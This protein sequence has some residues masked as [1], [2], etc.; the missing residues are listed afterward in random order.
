MTE[1]EMKEK[2]YIKY[3][4]EHCSNVRIAFLKYGE[5]LCRLLNVSL[6]SLEENINRHD[7]SKFSEEEFEGY[8]NWFYPCTDEEKN[9]EEYDKAWIH[10]YTNNPHHP[11][12]WIRDGYT[13]DMPSVFI[14]EMLCDWQGMAI[15]FGTSTYE[16]YLKERDKK[17]FSENTK[18]ILDVVV[19]EVFEGVK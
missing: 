7:Q 1:L 8:R 6:H 10:H 15:K 2:E 11:Q 17:G 13:E 16:Y 18:K 12:Y 3:I 14:A 4:N 19:K 5:Q 9:K